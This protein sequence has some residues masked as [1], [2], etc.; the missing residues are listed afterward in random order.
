MLETNLFSLFITR[1]EKANIDYFIGGSVASIVYGEPRLTHDIDLVLNINPSYAS[2]IIENFPLDEFYTP[3]LDVIT[4]EIALGEKGHFNIIHHS[5][6]FKADLYFVGNDFLQKWALENKRMIKFID[7]E[8]PIAPP[9]YVIVKKMLFYN[10]GKSVKHIE[11]IRG[12]LRESNQLIDFEILYRF[13]EK[14]NLTELYNN[15]FS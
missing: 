3:P 8:I 14:Y 5:S 12:I 13:L 10:E 4:S 11:D 7:L 1:I 9:E 15:I 6:G 2:R